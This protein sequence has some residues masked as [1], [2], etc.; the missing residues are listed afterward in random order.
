MADF[1]NPGLLGT[2]A[3][4]RNVFVRPIDLGNDRDASDEAKCIAKE[5]SE[6]LHH[7][8]NQF[9]LRRTS[10]VNQVRHPRNSPQRHLFHM[11]NFPS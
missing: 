5:R 3:T 9:V 2:L 7:T 11:R 6:A 10:E 8:M 4:F 1:V